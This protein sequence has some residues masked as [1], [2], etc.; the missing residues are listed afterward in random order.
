MKFLVAAVFIIA[1]ASVCAADGAL[2]SGGLN[3][4]LNGL[5]LEDLLHGLNLASIV[6]NTIGFIKDTFVAI[7]KF[8][9]YSLDGA[10]ALADAIADAGEKYGSN[11]LAEFGG[12]PSP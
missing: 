4:L 11:F 1:F 5:G 9:G 10:S 7:F 6:S 2:G 3:D 8:F 12:G